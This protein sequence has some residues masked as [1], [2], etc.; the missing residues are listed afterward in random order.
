MV[1]VGTVIAGLYLIPWTPRKPFVRALGSVRSGMTLADVRRM[2][3]GYLESSR[4]GWRITGDAIQEPV[5]GR[6]VYFRH[7]EEPEFNADIGSVYFANGRVT[8]VG[9]SP[10]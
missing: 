1:A 8:H 7:S 10:D 4:T 3:A 6:V 5:I 2:M 9:F